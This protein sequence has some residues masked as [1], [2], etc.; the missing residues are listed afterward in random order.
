MPGAFD[1]LAVL[2]LHGL[3]KNTKMMLFPYL[4]HHDQLLIK[5]GSTTLTTTGTFDSHVIRLHVP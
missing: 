4:F 1:T 5:S 3:K 2:V